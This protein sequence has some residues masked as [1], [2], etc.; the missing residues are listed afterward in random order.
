MTSKLAGWKLPVIDGDMNI[1]VGGRPYGLLSESE[2]WRADYLLA[3]AISHVSGRR[4]LVLDRMD[5]LDAPGRNDLIFWLADM[6][7]ANAFDTALVLGTMRRDQLEK[8]LP[9]LP[10]NFGVFWM[11]G[12]NLEAMSATAKA[13]EVA[14]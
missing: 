13:A 4:L 6:A 10:D 1:T 8:A 14:A 7:D 3:E 12:G 5:V 2:K 11:E 9:G